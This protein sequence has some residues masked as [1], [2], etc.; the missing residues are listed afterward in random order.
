LS[1]CVQQYSLI[2][3][4]QLPPPPPPP[5]ISAH[6]RGGTVLVSQDR[7]H[8][9]V[10]PWPPLCIVSLC[11]HLSYELAFATLLL[12]TFDLLRGNGLAAAGLGVGVVGGPAR[13][14][15]R[16]VQLPPLSTP[17][18]EPYLQ[19]KKIM[20]GQFVLLIYDKCSPLKSACCGAKN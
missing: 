18:L 19:Q 2:E 7:R 10:T 8:L 12:A 15:L 9:F 11:S 20:N 1:S 4:P 17:V 16:V 3:T 14:L 13:A 6:I 5:R